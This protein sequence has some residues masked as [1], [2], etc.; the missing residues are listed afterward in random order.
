MN[1]T[2]IP[3]KTLAP[4][5]GGFSVYIHFCIEAEDMRLELIRHE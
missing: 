3:H 2:E 5:G 4:P 1:L